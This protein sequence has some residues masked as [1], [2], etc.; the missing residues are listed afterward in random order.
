MDLDSSGRV[1][2]APGLSAR[3]CCWINKVPPIGRILSHAG[4]QGPMSVGLQIQT[5]HRLDHYDA[6]SRVYPNET[7]PKAKQSLTYQD[8]WKYIDDDLLVERQ[9]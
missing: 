9:G 8:W 6:F 3:V 4:I 5:S 7:P 2:M 1:P